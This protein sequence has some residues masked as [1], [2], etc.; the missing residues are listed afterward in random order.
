MGCPGP[1]GVKSCS[2]AEGK[3]PLTLLMPTM[4]ILRQSRRALCC[5][6][7][8]RAVVILLRSAHLVSPHPHKKTAAP[9]EGW[10]MFC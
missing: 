9:R 6:K 2:G 3:Q 1:K 8:L 4:A 10:L 5:L 7:R